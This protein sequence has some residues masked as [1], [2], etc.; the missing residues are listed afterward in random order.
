MCS[1][2]LWLEKYAR[3]AS[4]QEAGADTLSPQTSNEDLAL[5]LLLDEEVVVE[6][7]ALLEA[8]RQEWAEEDI[9]RTT[10][11]ETF[12]RGGAHTQATVGTP[13]DCI[14]ARPCSEA[15]RSWVQA[16]FFTKTAAFAYKKYGE[17]A[18][19]MLA[20]GWC[21]KMQYLF[22]LYVDGQQG[23]NYEYQDAEL[24]AYV[25]DPAYMDWV[26]ALPLDSPAHPRHEEIKSLKP[27]TKSVSRPKASA[28]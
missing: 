4:S 27:R 12:I 23:D 22:D 18:A 2:D 24:A 28:V 14:I 15:A 3:R 21:H 9:V 8:R 17:T 6:T 5:P 10:D 20:M 1:S 13:Y 16:F 19:N 11:F 25:P 7:W 26:L